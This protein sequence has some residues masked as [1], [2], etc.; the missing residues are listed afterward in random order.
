MGG[1]D[2]EAG[3][4][5][6]ALYGSSQPGEEPRE[7][8]VEVPPLAAVLAGVGET[9]SIRQ[10][11]KLLENDKLST[12]DRE[13]LIDQAMLCLSELYVHRD[14]KRSNSCSR[15]GDRPPTA[16][17]DVREPEASQLPS[18]NDADFQEPV[19]HP[20]RL[21][22]AQTLFRHG[23]LPAVPAR[24]LLG[25]RRTEEPEPPRRAEQS[26][27]RGVGAPRPIPGHEALWPRRPGGELERHADPPGDPRCRPRGAGIQPGR[28]VRHGP[29][30]DDCPVVRRVFAA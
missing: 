3:D 10:A 5:E 16:Q 20:H 22:L 8:V 19:G 24:G 12:S 27:H 26:P 6:D 30:A 4:W 29:A 15:P 28:G 2:D 23:R 13:G 14:F 7:V 1:A 11:F 17:A 21:Y 18:R 25:T 9:M